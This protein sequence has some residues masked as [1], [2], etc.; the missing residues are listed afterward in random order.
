M[1]RTDWGYD[2]LETIAKQADFIKELAHIVGMDWGSA[3]VW[4]RHQE[5][6]KKVADLATLA[7]Q[8]GASH[9]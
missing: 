6:K 2:P 3:N 8:K 1:D 5:L 4:T 9:E 7:Q